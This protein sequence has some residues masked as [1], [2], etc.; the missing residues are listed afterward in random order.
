MLKISLNL[1]C[2][3]TSRRRVPASLAADT[4]YFHPP[5]DSQLCGRGWGVCPRRGK[6]LPLLHSA[7]RA[8]IRETSG[9]RFAPE[10]SWPPPGRQKKLFILGAVKNYRVWMEAVNGVSEVDKGGPPA[11][12]PLTGCYLLIVVGEPHSKE[13]KD[14]IL[15]RIAKGERPF[16]ILLNARL[17]KSILRQK[18]N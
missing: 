3:Q 1:E 5:P 10:P 12:S 16:I 18:K 17:Q 4:S 7:P 2:A 13:H 11:P 8:G 6:G 15:R 14:I 9:F